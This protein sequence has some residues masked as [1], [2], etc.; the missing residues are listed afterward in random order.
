[1][2]QLA[3][4]VLKASAKLGLAANPTVEAN[5]LC[6]AMQEVVTD[7]HKAIE[8]AVC[9]SPHSTIEKLEGKK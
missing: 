8:E 6:E 7:L 3:F 9:R 2:K 5:K 1:M 4:A